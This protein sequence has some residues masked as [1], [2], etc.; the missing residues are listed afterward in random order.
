M[1][2]RKR[3]YGVIALC[4][5]IVLFYCLAILGRISSFLLDDIPLVEDGCIK[6]LY[7]LRQANLLNLSRAMQACPDVTWIRVEH[8]WYETRTLMVVKSGSDAGVTLLFDKDGGLVDIQDS[9]F[10]LRRVRNKHV[11]DAFIIS[12]TWFRFLF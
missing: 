8:P 10:H 1:N 2:N 9:V 4:I 7:Q 11:I 6:N 3:A 5:V 12:L